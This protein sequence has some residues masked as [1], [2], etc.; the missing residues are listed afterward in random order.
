M[1]LPLKPFIMPT[2]DT[3]DADKGRILC[4]E[5]DLNS[6]WSMDKQEVAQ[7]FWTMFILHRHHSFGDIWSDDNE[8]L[9]SFIGD[10]QDCSFKTILMLELTLQDR[11]DELEESS[12]SSLVDKGLIRWE[13]WEQWTG[14]ELRELRV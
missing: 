8:V 6:E 1:T 4:I 7:R 14:V 13:L 9:V 3:P 11:W 5:Y 12:W 2:P 10:E